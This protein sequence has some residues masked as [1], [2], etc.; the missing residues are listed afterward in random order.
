[1]KRTKNTVVRRAREGILSLCS[2]ET[3]PLR[4]LH[5]ALESPAGGGHRA[6]GV[7]PEQGQETDERA[8]APLLWR[9]D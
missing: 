1:M 2:G 9:S 6:V 3:S 4:V 8:G 5:P 7:S